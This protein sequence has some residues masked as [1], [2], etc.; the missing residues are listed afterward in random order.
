MQL[1]SAGSSC[2]NL[3]EQHDHTQEMSHVAR[4]SEDIHDASRTPKPRV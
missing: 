4:Q 3:Q 2:V 1:T